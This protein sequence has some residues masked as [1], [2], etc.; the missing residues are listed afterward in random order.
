M[1]VVEGVAIPPL[2]GWPLVPSAPTRWPA[3]QSHL[4]GSP[5]ATI[6]RHSREFA[7]G[8]LG[9]GVTGRPVPRTSR[10]SRSSGGR[11]ILL[12]APAP[13]ETSRSTSAR[14]S[15][16]VAVPNPPRRSGTALSLVHLTDPP[17][18]P[19]ASA[20]ATFEAVADEAAAWERRPRRLHGGTWSTTTRRSTGS[21]PVMVAAS[22]GRLGMF[23]IPGQSRPI[24]PSPQDPARHSKNAG[25]HPTSG[26]RWLPPRDR[27]EY[28]GDRR[29][30]SFPLGSPVSTF[31]AIPE[32]DFPGSCSATLRT[33]SRRAGA[34]GGP[35]WSSSGHNHGGQIRL[36]PGRGPVFMPSILLPAFRPGLSSAWTGP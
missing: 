27:G 24:A 6:F 14:W 3:W 25:V 30:T 9:Q 13:G 17:L 34:R 36:P 20:D 35:T 31:G 23:A 18:R 1:I 7:V 29:G 33:V 32:A 4:S 19:L 28:P 16:R 21:P 2:A 5:M 11:Q 26:G 12:D 22:G 8:H 10:R 15:G